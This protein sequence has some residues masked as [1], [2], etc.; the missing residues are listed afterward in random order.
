[1]KLENRISKFWKTVKAIFQKLVT[2]I[3]KKIGSRQMNGAMVI[4]TLKT[5]SKKI[6]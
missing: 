2:S 1:M 5:T 4:V 6:Q 3:F